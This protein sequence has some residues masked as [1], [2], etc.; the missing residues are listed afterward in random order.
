MFSAEI[1]I[2]SICFSRTSLAPSFFTYS[3]EIHMHIDEIPSSLLFLKL[4]NHSSLSFLR[5]E[6]LQSLHAP[7]NTSLDSVLCP[8][9]ALKSSEQG[10]ALSLCSLRRGRWS[11]H[12]ACW[13]CFSSC[14]PEYSSAFFVALSNASSFFIHC[15]LF[16][17]VDVEP[18]KLQQPESGPR[19][20]T[21][22]QKEGGLNLT[23]N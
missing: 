9:S 10:T 13:Q 1:L 11:H 22:L 21:S 6:M 5:W 3:L 12:P 18:F 7:G 17:F 14:S 8:I 23:E 16:S 2:L 20:S 4:R 19:E 15:T